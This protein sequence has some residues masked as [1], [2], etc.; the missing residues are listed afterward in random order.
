MTAALKLP[1]FDDL[2]AE[3][4]ALPEGVTGE[5]L[6]PGVLRTMSRPGKRHRSAAKNG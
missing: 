3:I 6:E 4:A 5:I 2:Y 1:T